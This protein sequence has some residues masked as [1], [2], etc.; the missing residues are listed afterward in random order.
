MPTYKAMICSEGL[1]PI[2]LHSQGADFLEQTHFLERGDPNQKKGV[3]TQSFLQVLM[4]H[5]DGEKHWQETPP[6]GWRTS[7]RRRSLSNWLV[8]VEHG[9]GHLLARVIVNRLWQNHFGRG[10]VGTPS[11][12]GLQGERP[13]HPELLDWLAAELIEQ[14]WR[15]KPIHRLIVSS[16]AYRQ[17]TAF[18]RERHGIDADNR[19]VWRRVPRRLEAEIIRDSLLAVAG[20]LDRRMFGPG[21][22]APDYKRRSV[23]FFVK[24]SQLVPMMVLFDAPDGTVGIESR[25]NTTIA[26]QALLLMNNPVVRDASRAFAARL[27]GLTD[28]EAVRQGYRLAV[29]RSPR[30]AELAEST[31]FLAEQRGSY[32]QEKKA[33]ADLLALTDFCQVLLGLN[34]FVYID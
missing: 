14:G 25:T 8:D 3:A 34:E 29:G 2:R 31:S 12:F 6:P 5:P 28:A 13:T 10:I 4:R 18:D 17:G 33:D 11:D 27:R 22:L 26:P 7:Y 19:L 30:A 9:A 16:A 21:S 24:R 23:Y 15:L 1:K 32:Q 20:Q